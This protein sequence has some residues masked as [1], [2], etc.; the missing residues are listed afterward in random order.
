MLIW[1]LSAGLT[2]LN[3]ILKHAILMLGFFGMANMVLLQVRISS[4]LVR[5]IDELCQEGLFRNRSEAVSD[6]I[7]MLLA[8]YSHTSPEARATALYLGGRLGRAGNPEDIVFRAEER[9][10]GVLEE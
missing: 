8:R 5:R 4:A 9:G 1:T 2:F 3:F 7:R 6:A 10:A